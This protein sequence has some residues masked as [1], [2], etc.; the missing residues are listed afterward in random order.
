MELSKI[1]TR[2]CTL[3]EIAVELEVL[4]QTHVTQGNA[5]RDVITLRDAITFRPPILE[6]ALPVPLDLG[7]VRLIPEREDR[8]AD[9]LVI[10]QLRFIIRQIVIRAFEKASQKPEALETKA[11]PVVDPTGG[12]VQTEKP[13]LGIEP[14]SSWWTVCACG[15]KKRDHSPTGCLHV[16]CPCRISRDN[17]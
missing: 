7:N 4:M 11:L 10:Q 14:S 12:V 8:D 9:E 17:I 2:A 6:P 3:E 16:A 13:P 15:H 5:N 1:A